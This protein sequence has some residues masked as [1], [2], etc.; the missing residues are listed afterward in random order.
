MGNGKKAP[1]HIDSSPLPR[2]S[3]RC[4]DESSGRK[5]ETRLRVRA[6][7]GIWIACWVF[8]VLLPSTAG[9]SGY[10]EYVDDSCEID[11]PSLD[12]GVED[13]MCQC[14]L[15]FQSPGYS[16][17]VDVW[18]APCADLRVPDEAVFWNVASGVSNRHVNWRRRIGMREKH[19]NQGWGWGTDPMDS[20]TTAYDLTLNAIALLVDAPHRRYNR[21]A[22]R[23]RRGKLL[24]RWAP[25]YVFERIWRLRPSCNHGANARSKPGWRVVLHRRFFSDDRTYGAPIN[26]VHR[27]SILLHEARHQ[28]PCQH[29]ANGPEGRCS[30]TSCD[31]SPS[32]GCKGG[33]RVGAQG[34]GWAWLVQFALADP[35]VVNRRVA[36]ATRR[37]DAAEVANARADLAFDIHPGV[38]LRYDALSREIDIVNISVGSCSD[39][40]NLTP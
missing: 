18:S 21:I 24:I 37:R 3:G 28:A 23:F 26:D 2:T 22:P 34:F 40:P 39:V 1:P 31:Y 14:C 32:D 38:C 4:G 19:W 13:K 9:A 35:T 27:A 36:T 10:S 15:H 17:C 8:V 20:I 12:C 33:R 16:E 30:G 11:A 7:R 5:S 25:E 29:N 6:T